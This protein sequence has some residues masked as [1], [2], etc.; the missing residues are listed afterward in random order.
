[1]VRDWVGVDFKSEPGSLIRSTSF[2]VEPKYP[3]SAKKAGKEGEVIY[4]RPSMKMVSHETFKAL[5]S[6]GFG[7]EEAA[8]AALKKTSFRPAMRGDE[9]ISK[10]VAI[11]YKFTLKDN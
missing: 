2:R 1:M 3:D 10:Q 8:I 9:P 6:L 5:T 7:L 4:R 11:P